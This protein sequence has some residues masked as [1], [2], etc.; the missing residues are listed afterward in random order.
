M[1]G[2]GARKT[3]LKQSGASATIVEATPEPEPRGLGD[4]QDGAKAGGDGR[5]SRIDPALAAQDPSPSAPAQPAQPQISAKEVHFA[6]AFARIV[7]ILMRSNPYR[8]SSLADLEWL[9]LPPIMSGQFAIL[10][11]QINGQ[12]VPIAVALWANVSAE[13][14]QRL[15]DPTLPSI[16]LKPNEWRSGEILWLIDAVGDGS[17][18]PHLMQRLTEGPFAGRQVKMR[19]AG[20]DG[21]VSV[22]LLSN[23]FASAVRA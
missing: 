18:I 7:S 8:H 19:R 14:D 1:F 10:D 11:A 13:I 4:Q 15:S 9:V 17:A 3:S 21:I 6:V 16:K 22:G 20:A 23:V 12:T 5:H 2:L